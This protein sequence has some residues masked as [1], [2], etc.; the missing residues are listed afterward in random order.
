M[1]PAL[2]RR[3]DEN[4][5]RIGRLVR[6]AAENSAEIEAVAGESRATTSHLAE[7][8]QGKPKA[9]VARQWFEI[10]RNVI[11]L[12]AGRPARISRRN[13]RPRA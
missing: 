3:G 10:F 4:L 12:V 11:F 9:G 7:Q 5:G 1:G 13:K 8:N 2:A 6:G